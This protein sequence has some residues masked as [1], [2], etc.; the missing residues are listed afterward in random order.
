[1]FEATIQPAGETGTAHWR[2]LLYFN[3]YRLI[4]ALILLG[5]V[6]WL[7]DN[8]PFGSYNREFFI[9]VDLVYVA[10]TLLA[11]APIVWQ[12]PRFEL[13]LSIYVCLDVLAIA[14]LLYAS[15]GVVSGLELLLLPSLAAAGLL[16]MGRLPL[17]YAAMASFAIL[18]EQSF[19]VLYL[20]G[21]S[22]LFLRA[23]LISIGYFA[24]AWLGHSLASRAVAIE[25]IVAQR[26][27]DLASM[28]QINKLIIQDMQDGVIVADER[29][30][31]RQ[32]NTR[33]EQLLGRVTKND[34]D[35]EL[36][37]Y[38]PTLATHLQNW[39][40]NP[41][42]QAEPM[43]SVDG[44]PSVAARFRTVSEEQNVGVVIFLEDLSRIQRQAQ[45]MKLASLGRLTANI[46]HEIRNPL[47]AINHAAELLIEDTNE[48]S[49]AMRLL[50]I[51]HDNTQRLDRMVQDVL[52]LNRRD[53]ALRETF[54]VVDYLRTFVGQFAEIEK[55]PDGVIAIEAEIEPA[56]TFDRS[57]L[58]QIMWNLCRNALRY[59]L[60]QK[61]SITLGVR[62]AAREGSVELSV[63]DDGPGVADALRGNLF[64]PF[65][66]TASSGT[67]LG[68]YIARE[69]CE[70]NGA[71]LEYVE[72]AGGG[73][74]FGVLF[75]GAMQ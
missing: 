53:R 44:D 29:G 70:A 67:G 71:R 37:D 22:A 33:T 9:T 48:A 25:A 42:A 40:E 13:Q 43:Q 20:D 74:Q 8:I 36:A 21:N 14:L 51:I 54:G 35:V 55:V 15:G 59:C 57:H 4:V 66:T 47:S 34:R 11:F 12:R 64:E 63:K 24:T 31:I 28:A 27:V 38:A 73:A 23:G 2:S 3:I 10:L 72:R 75:K 30:V 60:R 56:V 58:N 50:Q 39:R 49:G 18:C 7:S 5:S 19:E 46:A 62:P 32:V 69:I 26:E 45:Q 17:F 52:R 1:M 61:G 16:A 68:L 41:A 6:V 65:F